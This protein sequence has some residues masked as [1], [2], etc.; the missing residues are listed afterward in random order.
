MSFPRVRL[1]VAAALFIAWLGYLAFLVVN[2]RH[3]MV[4]S[5]SQWSAADTIVV[6]E[7]VLDDMGKP[8]EEVSL[9]ESLRGKDV[10]KTFRVPGLRDALPPTQQ[11][12]TETRRLLLLRAVP[13]GG[14]QIAE[15]PPS[16]GDGVT[17]RYVYPWSPEVER[18]ARAL[19][20]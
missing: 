14:Y 18:Q 8:S 7:V 19:L 16:P 2:Y 3:P 6:A 1:Y 9:V 12:F 4:V 11:P 17:R 20:R 15:T 5:R 10:A 13:G